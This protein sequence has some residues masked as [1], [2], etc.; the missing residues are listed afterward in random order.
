MMTKIFST[1]NHTSNLFGSG[2]NV[3]IILDLGGWKGKLLK[4][5]VSILDG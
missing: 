4:L 2:F 5:E 1:F 3:E